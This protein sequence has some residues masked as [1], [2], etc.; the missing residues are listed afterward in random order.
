LPLHITV[1]VNPLCRKD[2]QVRY[3]FPFT[4]DMAEERPSSN[5]LLAESTATTSALYI[6]PFCTE[7]SLTLMYINSGNQECLDDLQELLANGDNPDHEKRLRLLC[8][9]PQTGAQGAVF[10]CNIKADIAFTLVKWV[11]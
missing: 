1:V 8:A 11:R 7:L 5:T 4:S 3:V 2:G 6:I 9:T 10:R